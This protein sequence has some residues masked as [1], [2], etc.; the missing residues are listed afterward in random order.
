MRYLTL[1]LLVFTACTSFDPNILKNAAKL[2]TIESLLN[3]P[4]ITTSFADA[5]AEVPF[6]DRAIPEKTR[7]F[8][9]AGMPRDAQGRYLLAPGLY[10][11][12]A[13]SYC[14]QAGTH[15]PSQGDGYLYAPLRGARTKSVQ[16]ILRRSVEKP[17]VT[18]H[19][20]QVLLWA[21]IARA[22]YSELNPRLKQTATAL[23]TPRELLELEGGAIGILRDQLLDRYIEKLSPQLQKIFRAEQQLR[24]HLNRV[25]ATYQEYEQLAVL[26][27]L[28]PASDVIRPTPRG[29][30]SWHPDGYFIR[31][32]PQGYQRT[33]MQVYVPPPMTVERDGAGKIVALDAGKLFRF[34]ARDG[35]VRVT[36]GQRSLTRKASLA[37][38]ERP[39]LR[40]NLAAMKTRAETPLPAETVGRVAEVE[41]W[42]RA[43]RFAI[44]RPGLKKQDAW[45]GVAL[46]VLT[47][48][49]AAAL[50]TELGGRPGLVAFDPTANVA[51]PANTSAQRLA[52][53][54]EPASDEPWYEKLPNCPCTWKTL[55]ARIGQTAEPPGNW[56][57]ATGF[58]F[59][60]W[61]FH[62][63]AAT[64]ARW[65]PKGGGPG[66]QCT[67]DKN[68]KLITAGL[69]AGTPDMMSPDGWDG[70]LQHFEKD[71]EPFMFFWWEWL[72]RRN[73]MS[74][75][76][77]MAT[78]PPNTGGCK[79]N[80]VKMPPTPAPL[81]CGAYD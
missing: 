46:A 5:H 39:P 33:K 35:Q 28:A 52:S 74:C 20:V 41:E 23:L 51:V 26:A 54:G 30:W 71:V 4:P 69:A 57:D 78:Y 27:G 14:I 66:Q 34:E 25:N 61:A 13:Q 56:M 7:G 17:E 8:P 19:D 53:G 49:P 68:G 36:G 58:G 40:A 31:Y 32:F 6:L 79:S 2:P 67:Y 29:R 43:V 24:H 18:Q 44:A 42:A 59:L 15:A 65:A 55:R 70:V 47:H 38:K 80:A 77:Y 72:Y 50:S 16:A 62:D 9:L 37:P 21:V 1:L 12:D 11:L 45:A 22:K 48:A 3:R 76:A 75:D 10:E 81:S 63:G 64:A 73:E 60:I